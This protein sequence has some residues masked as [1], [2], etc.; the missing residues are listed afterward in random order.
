MQKTIWMKRLSWTLPLLFI[1]A[2]TGLSFKNPSDITTHISDQTFDF[3]QRLKPRA[4]T[5]PHSVYI[6]FD[7]KSVEKLGAWPWPRTIIA[8]ILRQT[9][10]AGAEAV[11]LDLPL[12]RRDI[13]SPKQAVKAW[14]QLPNNPEF[15]SLHDTLALLPDHD[16]ELADA[17]NE[18]ITIV[19]IVPGTSHGQ[20]VLRRSTPIAQSGGNILRHVPTFETRQPALDIFRNAAHGI[21]ITLPP[22]PHNENVRSLPLLAALSGE[23][24]PASALE[25]IRLSQKANGY[26]ISLIEPVKAI[27]LMKIPGIQSIAL[28]NPATGSNKTLVRTDPNG[29]LRLYYRNER[30]STRIPAW[31]LLE[32][33]DFDLT[34]RIAV[35]GRSVNGNEKKYDTVVGRLAAGDIIAEAIDQIQEG[36]F[37]IRPQWAPLAEQLTILVGGLLLILIVIT[38]RGYWGLVF[39]SIVIGGSAYG[40]WYAFSTLGLLIDPT[41]PALALLITF[42]ICAVFHRWHKD[43]GMRFVEAQFKNRLASKTFRKVV[44]NPKLVKAEGTLRPVTSLVTGLRGF[45]VIAD[46]Y[47]DDPIAYADILNRFF[48]PMTKLVHERDGMVDRHVGDTMLTVW[49]APLDLKDHAMKA[50]DSALRMTEQLDALNEFLEEDARR[51]NLSYVPLSAS[52]GIDSGDG[53]MGNIGATQGFDFG[54]TGEPVTFASYLQ[55]H[56]RD[57]GPAVIVGE[58]TKDLVGSAFALLEV[59]RI[60]TPR[61]PNGRAVYALLG[62]SIVRASP[63]FQALANGQKEFFAAYSAQNWTEARAVIARVRQLSGAISTLYDFYEARVNQH[64]ASAPPPGWDGKFYVGRI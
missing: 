1:V 36:V 59:D 61:H 24:Q 64:E 58:G 2:A 9:I 32:K 18:G 37:L 7:A 29:S 41:L 10:E 51:Q 57:Y 19:S 34:G 5:A 63:K 30:S 13:T 50:C 3:Y 23:V 33:K 56:A 6:D 25:A 62:D 40:S 15:V 47:L 27:A 12:A 54:V 38:T 52:I 46:R 60:S 31:E 4:T 49:N 16:D 11:I 8:D 44:N 42:I 17:L 35:I 28:D 21:G 55:R 22:T 48:T 43:N 14:G 26:N 53:I 45:N 39:L 20:D